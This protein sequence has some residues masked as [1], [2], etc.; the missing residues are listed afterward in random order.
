VRNSQGTSRR[1]WFAASMSAEHAQVMRALTRGGVAML[2][3]SALTAGFGV[4]FWLVAA[5]LLTQV[6]V[7][8]GSALVSTL[9]IVSAFCQLNYARSLSRLIPLA[10]RPRRLLANVYGITVAISLAVGLAA[11]F[12]IPLITGEFASLRGDVF[13]VACFTVSVGIW[14]I[15][16]LEDAALTSVRRATIMPFENGAYGLL[17]LVCIVALW[18]V[19]YRGGMAIFVSWILPLIVVI[20]PVNLYL[21]LRAVPASGLPRV[22]RTGRSQPWLRYDFAGYLLW[23]AGTLPLPLLVLLIVGPAQSAIFFVTFTIA[24]AIDILSLNLGN[25]LTAELSPSGGVLTA[26]TKSFLFRVWAA[27]GVLSALTF[28]LAPE[29]LQV[30]GDRYRAGGTV[31]LRTFMVATLCRSVL[32]MG[33]AI[34]RSRGEGRSILLLQSIA[35]LGTLGL[36]LVLTHLLGAVGTALAWAVAS[37]LAACVAVLL[38]RPVGRRANRTA[39]TGPRT[40]VTEVS[41]PVALASGV[42]RHVQGAAKDTASA[43]GHG[44]TKAA[45]PAMSVTF[46]MRLWATEAAAFAMS[47]PSAMRLSAAKAA[48]SAMSVTFAMRLRAAKTAASAMSAAKAAASAM[49]AGLTALP[50][51]IARLGRQSRSRAALGLAVNRPNDPYMVRVARRRPVPMEDADSLNNS[52]TIESAGPLT[53]RQFTLPSLSAVARSLLPL[54]ALG[55]GFFAMTRANV[56]A[57]GAYGLIQA[58]PP[59][60]YVALALAALSFLLTWNNPRFSPLRFSVDL[61]VLV[62]LLQSA[63]AVI[64][65]EARFPTAWLTA[66]FTDFVA[67]AGHVLPGI[68]A[69]FSWPGFFAGV[70]MLSR[71]AGLPST[72]LLLKWWPVAMNLLYLPPVYFLARAILRD[73]RRA[74]LATWLFPL[75][76]WVGQDYFSPQSVAFLLYITLVWIIVDQFGAKRRNLLPWRARPQDPR[77][78]GQPAAAPLAGGLLVRTARLVPRRAWQRNP[79]PDGHLADPEPDGSQVG[80]ESDDS[81]TGAEPGGSRAGP[82]ADGPRSGAE[83]DGPRSGAEPG[84][85]RSG[86]EPD[87]PQTA[88]PLAAGLLVR[89]A[90]LL[91]RRAPKQVAHPDGARAAVPVAL[92]LFVLT[93][94]GFAISVSHQ[95]TP[96]FAGSVVVLL[97][98]F[99]R[100][101]LKA[102]GVLLLL[103]TAAWICYAAVTFW[104]G[105]FNLM[106]GGFG[107]LSGNVN[108]SLLSRF[109]GTAQHRQILDVRL[110]IA[111][112]IWVLAGLGLVIGYRRRFEIRTPAILMIAPLLVLSGGRYGG[113]AGLRAYLFSLVGALPLVAMLLPAVPS[114]RA[115]AMSSVAVAL[116][117]ALLVPGFVLAR[118]G[119]ELSEMTRPGDI[120]AI[121]ALYR[122][123]PSGS[124]LIPITQEVPWRFTDINRYQYLFGSDNEFFTGN[125]GAIVGRVA[126]NPYGGYVLITTTGLAFGEQTYGQPKDWGTR[127]ERSLASSGRFVLVY[128]SPDAKI[129]KYKK[130]IYKSKKPNAHIRGPNASG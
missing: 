5:R 106:F 1:P 125:V 119:N 31:I 85:S 51:R 61:V 116:A 65:P 94:L 121:R 20:I 110:I 48:A 15:F 10:D 105:H 100:T 118:W 9:L 97:A 74:A 53:A 43:L 123:A 36:G 25:S 98:F 19:G 52:E 67:K 124:A 82:E 46:A 113:E 14:S 60:Y 76:N 12:V 70:G 50:G 115:S 18:R 7:G 114:R 96:V 13:F 130:P 83:A 47:V 23:L 11:A 34:L 91:P 30:F 93:A 90:K 6:T 95:I 24:Q 128:S 107:H 41:R 32:F 40:G 26:A 101:R 117:A 129:Y 58:L 68:D 39:G 88:G 54:A 57:I 64:E 127:V 62:L 38:L 71:A 81:R 102:F 89:S 27:V 87:V 16:N 56:S 44:A 80:A 17:K 86:A 8:R 3:N 69:R 122:I 45:A 42:A 66:G 49:G 112:F 72:I 79:E 126:H 109:K 77:P 73:R 22:E 99:G 2:A 63:P 92:G 84:G 35:A 103:F 120:A 37:G 111:C 28:V 75:A 55:I 33:I 21:F 59:L 104:V 78:D 108:A 29:I 4:L